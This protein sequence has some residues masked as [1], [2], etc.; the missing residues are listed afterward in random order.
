MKQPRVAIITVNYHKEEKTLRLIES[1]KK[2]NYT[3]YFITIVDNDSQPESFGNLGEDINVI[4][5]PENSGW[6]GGF[7]RAVQLILT[8]EKPDYF[9]LLNN[10]QVVGKD[11]L[12]ELVKTAEI[13]LNIG[14]VAPAIYDMNHPNQIQTCGGYMNFWTGIAVESKRPKDKT[15]QEVDGYKEYVDDCALLIRREV[16]ERAGLHDPTYF[17]YFE[18]PDWNIAARKAGFKIINNQNAKVYHEIYGSSEGKKSP[19]VVYHLARNR[20]LFMR[21]HKLLRFPIFLLIN[22]FITFPIHFTKYLFKK[23]FDLLIPLTKGYVVGTIKSI[24]H[25]KF[26]NPKI[27]DIQ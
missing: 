16:V 14:F 13:E 23:H 4:R 1:I 18:D 7:R 27:Y 6:A 8:N 26:S 17:L 20:I 2:L 21:K 5:N 11:M 10:D 12:K 9:L 22:T 15:V 24:L 19:T 3:N 25:P